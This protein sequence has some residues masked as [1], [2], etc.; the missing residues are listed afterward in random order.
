MKNKEYKNQNYELHKKQ[1]KT[2]GINPIERV[3]HSKKGQTRITKK[4]L[5]DMVNEE[6]YDMTTD[7]YL[8]SY[9]G[10]G[11]NDFSNSI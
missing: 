10:D 9:S 11:V 3:V 7:D 8:E 5:N 1:R 4:E 6:L 2:W